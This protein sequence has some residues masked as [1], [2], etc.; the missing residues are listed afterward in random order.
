MGKR[1]LTADHVSKDTNVFGD[2]KPTNWHG[3]T[4]IGSWEVRGIVQRP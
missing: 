3:M 4:R 1:L 2:G